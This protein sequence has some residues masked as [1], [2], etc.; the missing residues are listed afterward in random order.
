MRYPSP[1]WAVHSLLLATCHLK[2]NISDTAYENVMAAVGLWDMADNMALG[3]LT[4]KYTFLN[5]KF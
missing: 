3:C 2:A 1:H 5:G 4:L